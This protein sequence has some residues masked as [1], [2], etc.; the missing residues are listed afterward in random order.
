MVAPSS[1][2]EKLWDFILQQLWIS[3]AAYAAFI[4]LCAARDIMRKEFDKARAPTRALFSSRVWYR[5]ISKWYGQRTFF[6]VESI[7]LAM[8][9]AACIIYVYTTYLR[10]VPLYIAT[11]NRVFASFF[12]FNLVVGS[13]LAGSAVV[14]TLQFPRFLQVMSLVSLF[15]AVGPTAYLHFGFL[16]AFS[17]YDSYIRM[18]RRVIQVPFAPRKFAF[19]LFFQCLTLFY[20]LA[21]GIQMLEIPGDWLSLEFRNSWTNDWTFFNSIYWVIVTL[22]TVGYGDITPKTIQGRVY[23]LF[24]IIIGIIVFSNIIQDLFKEMRR[25]RGNGSYRDSTNTRH[26]IVSGTPSLAD[27]VHFVKE[28]YHRPSN[29]NAQIVLLVEDPKWTDLDWYRYVARNHFLHINVI[30]LIGSVLSVLDLQRAGINTAD[31]VFIL[32]TPASS[33]DPSEQDS[34]IVMSTLAIRNSRTDI[35]IFSQ[36]LL[37]HSN[38][39]ITFAMKTAAS[40]RVNRGLLFREHMSANAQYCGIY[41]TVRELE[42]SYLPVSLKDGLEKSSSDGN[43]DES[44]NDCG[45]GG[46]VHKDSKPRYIRDLDRSSNVCLQQ[47]YAA[48]LAANIKANGIGTLLTNLYLELPDAHVHQPWLAEYHLGAACSL[49][50][51]MVPKS[52]DGVEVK[53]VASLLFRR[54]IVIMATQAKGELVINTILRT[55]RKLVA[56]E[57]G[58][59]MTFLSAQ[60]LPAALHLVGLE[61]QQKEEFVL[62]ADFKSKY[63]RPE[64]SHISSPNSTRPR[65]SRRPSNTSAAAAAAEQSAL[66]QHPLTGSPEKRTTATANSSF[67]AASSPRKAKSSSAVHTQQANEDPRL[68]PSPLSGRPRRTRP[69][70]VPTTRGM[71]LAESRNTFGSRSLDLMTSVPGASSSGAL[72]DAYLSTDTLDYNYNAFDSNVARRSYGSM[73]LPVPSELR[74]HV[75]VVMEG[76]TPL[77]NLPFFL[78]LFWHTSRP[79]HQNRPSTPVVVIHPELNDSELAKFEKPEFHRRLHFV[80]ESPASPAAWEQARLKHARA[81]AT[82]ADYTQ[83]WRVTDAKTIYTLLTL[84]ALTT[85]QQNLFVC[86]ELIDEHSLEFLREP[87]RPRRRGARLGNPLVLPSQSQSQTEAV[88]L[89]EQVGWSEN[90]EEQG[91][92]YVTPTTPSDGGDGGGDDGGDGAGQPNEKKVEEEQERE[93]ERTD[94]YV[95]DYNSSATDGTTSSEIMQ[96]EENLATTA[97]FTT[98]QS[99]T[100]ESGADVVELSRPNREYLFSRVRYTSGELLVHSTADTLLVREYAEPGFVNFIMSLCGAHAENPGQKIRLVRIPRAMFK[101]FYEMDGKRVVEYGV[102]FERLIALGVTP[103]GLYRSGHA[104]AR[105]PKMKRVQRGLVAMQEAMV[106][107]VAGLSGRQNSKREAGGGGTGG[108]GGGDGT[109]TSWRNPVAKI[110]KNTTEV[111]PTT[112]RNERGQKQFLGGAGTP[113][114]KTHV[115][116]VDDFRQESVSGNLLPYVY[117]LPDANT[118]VHETDGVY[119]LCDDTFDLPTTWPEPKKATTT[120]TRASTGA[121]DTVVTS[122]DG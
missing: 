5:R 53:Q 64:G 61:W 36:T 18:E 19:R 8:N 52:L 22:S 14:Y 88:H 67:D 21:A 82:M 86:A 101:D 59:F 111:L 102:I 31:A 24:M 122:T 78:R 83:E 3:F 100:G 25:Q 44:D 48:L 68:R 113:K 46:G 95:G 84:D 96:E 41:E 54:G 79:S 37:E 63:E 93:Q 17:A 65:L 57:L 77:S 97:L 29:K 28:F 6:A 55:S 32:T 42:R 49:H 92:D 116:E 50:F 114:S 74:D 117:T 23:T 121:D 4:V 72:T 26:I 30:Y 118:L 38:L 91:D 98:K 120:T 1:L 39:Q 81:V 12:C 71:R 108:G 119:V 35:P 16:R 62:C 60:H 76:K 20:V 109:T 45:G 90:D 85:A 51:G 99:T 13:V 40:F 107:D 15:T 70:I 106:R 33:G 115:S 105:I 10:R 58:L 34:Q 69:P 89:T 87:N 112:V 11:V 2:E 27:L 104:P 73:E 103:L 7:R 94:V 56:G 47:M 110:V 80:T 43:S 9:L 66:R 75:I